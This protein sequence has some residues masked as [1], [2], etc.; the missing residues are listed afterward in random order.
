[1]IIFEKE[2]DGESI[3]DDEII[4]NYVKQQDKELDNLKNQLLQLS[5]EA[6]DDIERWAIYA[7]EWQRERY[8]YD[9]DVVK[10]NDR[11]KKFTKDI[12]K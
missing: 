1:M 5:Y 4:D 3:Y 11:I 10:W 7:D 12:R 6:L 8:H 9:D 2:Y